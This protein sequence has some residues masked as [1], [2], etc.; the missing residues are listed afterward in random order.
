MV[1]KLDSVPAKKE[2]TSESEGKGSDWGIGP[3]ITSDTN[4][5]K[6]THAANNQTPAL[7]DC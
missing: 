2:Q 4:M 3:S 1:L 7:T 5:F 6:H